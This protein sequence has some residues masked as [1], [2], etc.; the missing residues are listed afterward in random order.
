MKLDEETTEARSLRMP[1]YVDYKNTAY[2]R[3]FLNPHGR[4]GS[5]KKSRVPAKHQRQIAEAVKRARY[6]ALLPYV[7]R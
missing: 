7:A 5:K 4:M 6:M 1:V 3:Q 2:L